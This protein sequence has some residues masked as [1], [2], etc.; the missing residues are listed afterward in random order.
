MLALALLCATL[1]GC[2]QGA[3]IIVDQTGARTLFTTKMIS[4]SG[5]ACIRNLEVYEGEPDGRAPLWQIVGEPD[6]G[7]VTQVE[8][9]KVPEGFSQADG[10]P[11]NLKLKSGQHYAVQASGRGWLAFGGFDAR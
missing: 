3:E 5:Q 1:S 10:T 9:A 7:C 8:F 6:D 11:A 4:S 2:Q